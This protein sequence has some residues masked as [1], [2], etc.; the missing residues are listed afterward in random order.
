MKYATSLLYPRERHLAMAKTSFFKIKS[1]QILVIS[2]SS[3]VIFIRNFNRRFFVFVRNVSGHASVVN[4]DD[5]NVAARQGR[6][7]VAV[8]ANAKVVTDVAVV[9]VAA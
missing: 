5:V 1:Y 4:E 3:G 2:V 9:A 8:D 7:P 6:H